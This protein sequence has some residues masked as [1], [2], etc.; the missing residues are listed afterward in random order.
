M[1]KKR[2][3][4]HLPRYKQ[5]IK[6]LA[7]VKQPQDN[8]TTEEV[9]LGFYKE[10]EP[11]K[12]NQEWIPTHRAYGRM[13]RIIR[14]ARKYLI[15]MQAAPNYSILTDLPGLDGI[16]SVQMPAVKNT[17]IER[18]QRRIRKMIESATARVEQLE[19]LK[20]LSPKRRQTNLG[21]AARSSGI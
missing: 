2:N 5:Y 19:E 17:E 16:H 12:K 14:H 10:Q 11:T 1:T 13:Y 15:E 21:K 7:K 9:T 8:W 3:I 18:A 6:L 4:A 20:R